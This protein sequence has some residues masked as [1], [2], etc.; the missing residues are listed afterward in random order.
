MIFKEQI[1]ITKDLKPLLCANE[2]LLL[3]L[4]VL[5]EAFDM[6]VI[7]LGREYDKWKLVPLL[8]RRTLPVPADQLIVA[9]HL[10]EVTSEVGLLLLV[11]LLLKDRDLLLLLQ[12]RLQKVQLALVVLFAKPLVLDA[13]LKGGGAAALEDGL[14]DALELFAGGVGLDVLAVFLKDSS[15]E[16]NVESVVDSAPDVLFGLVGGLGLFLTGGLIR[17]LSA[18]RILIPNIV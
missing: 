4:L 10:L 18:I 15:S 16:L 12:A 9:D 14:V 3:H 1:D 6:L 5:K 2:Q 13:A 7:I 8:G 11:D 17:N